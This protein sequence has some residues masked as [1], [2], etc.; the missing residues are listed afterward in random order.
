MVL[1]LNLSYE[2]NCGS[3]DQY[4]QSIADC[5]DQKLLLEIEAFIKD[6]KQARREII[7]HSGTGQ[8]LTVKDYQESIAKAQAQYRAG[9]TTSQDD[10]KRNSR[11]VV[12]T[13]KA[14]LALNEHIAYLN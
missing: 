13:D 10:S 1:Y 6:L 12:W 3:E 2:I 4:L 14:V 7:G 11:K 5:D 9:K 8:P